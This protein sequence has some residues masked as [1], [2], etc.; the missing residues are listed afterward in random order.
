MSLDDS[1][2]ASEPWV[3]QMLPI[4][5]ASW[6]ALPFKLC[7]PAK[8]ICSH[9]PHGEPGA[10]TI[11][12]VP[13]HVPLPGILHIRY[14]WLIP[15][16]HDLESTFSRKEFWITIWVGAFPLLTDLIPCIGFH[17]MISLSWI[18]L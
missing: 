5:Q 3:M 8:W 13:M 18:P 11:G 4:S 9:S 16:A 14:P 10:F 12:P 1:V 17:Y 15:I 6:L 7:P 2:Q